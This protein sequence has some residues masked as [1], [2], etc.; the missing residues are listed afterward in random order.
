MEH[1]TSIGAHFPFLV[2]ILSSLPSISSLEDLHIHWCC[3][4]TQIRRSSVFPW[5]SHIISWIVYFPNALC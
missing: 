1:K 5:A 4:N 2:T 3:S